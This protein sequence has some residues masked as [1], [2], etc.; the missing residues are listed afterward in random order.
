[1]TPTVIA[2]DERSRSSRARPR[3]LLLDVHVEAS[4]VSG[5]HAGAGAATSA[6]GAV[7]AESSES[8]DEAI[9]EAWRQVEERDRGDDE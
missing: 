6:G 9:L 3:P 4:Y 5:Y 1:M 7:G 8:D 2:P